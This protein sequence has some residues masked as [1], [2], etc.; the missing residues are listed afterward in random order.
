M[1][2]EQ[3]DA[4]ADPSTANQSDVSQESSP[5]AP[6]ET[7]TQKVEQAEVPFNEHP[8]FQELIEER[9]YL[10]EQLA[11][12][13]NRQISQPQVQQAEADPYA[14]MDAETKA[15]YQN[16]DKRAE[17]IA[18]KIVAQ[19]EVVFSREL[20]ETKQILA[21]VA[22]ERF[23]SKH[24]DV[25]PD[26]PEEASIARLYGRGY[27]L[28]D[29]YKVAMFDKMQNQKVQQAQVKQKQII[30]QKVAANVETSTIP[31]GSGLPQAKKRTIRDFVEEQFA[32]GLA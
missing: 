2:E 31:A 17:Q 9:R 10:R 19:K 29:A 15:F 18:N 21:T 7:T 6:V 30:Q 8:R 25:A 13:N 24:P 28:E 26:S 3:L 20:A 4:Q 5:A 23:Q 22:Y 1:S 27:S 11:A 12:A 16:V 32:K 14:G